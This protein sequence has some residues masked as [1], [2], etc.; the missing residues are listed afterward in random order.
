MLAKLASVNISLV[1]FNLIPAFPMDGGRILR[2][3]L[4]MALPY[5]RATQIAAWIG[6]GLAFVFGFV[7]LFTNPLLVFI[8]FFVFLGA[9]QEAMTA[10]MK[11]VAH[12]LPVPKRW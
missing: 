8:A 5:G 9:Q 6:Q 2:S 12:N 3:L 1:L 4:A 7:G 10:Q 11:D